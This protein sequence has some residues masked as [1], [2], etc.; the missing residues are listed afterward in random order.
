VCLVSDD[1]AWNW[2]AVMEVRWCERWRTVDSN[3]DARVSPKNTVRRAMHRHGSSNT[4]VTWTPMLMGLTFDKVR[5]PLSIPTGR[6]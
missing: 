5:D 6:S 2:L 1:K 4:S 3:E